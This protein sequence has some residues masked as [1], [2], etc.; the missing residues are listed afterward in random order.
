MKILLDTHYLI[1]ILQGKNFSQELEQMLRDPENQ[2]YFSVIS[3]WEIAIKKHSRPEKIPFTASDILGYAKDSGFKMIRLS[4]LHVLA[5][6]SLKVK[7]GRKEHR[8]PFD[9]ILIAQAKSEQMHFL[10]K[11]SRISAYDEE[12]IMLR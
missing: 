2:I 3:I 6:D 11:D 10:T 8:D 9:R 1:W 12:C 5:L 4:E 7:V